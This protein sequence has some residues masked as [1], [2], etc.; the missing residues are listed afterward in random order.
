M[1]WVV[2]DIFGSNG[3]WMSLPVDKCEESEEYM[4]MAIVMLKLSVDTAEQGVKDIKDYANVAKDSDK[5][6]AITLIANSYQV[7]MPDF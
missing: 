2:F 7:K 1:S 4:K 3:E 6:G 5:C